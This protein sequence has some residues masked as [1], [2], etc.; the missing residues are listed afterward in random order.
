MYH[1]Y[2][3]TYY[4]LA[5]GMDG[6]PDERDFGIVEAQNE[7]A[8]KLIVAYRESTTTEERTWMLGCLTATKL[9]SEV[10]ASNKSTL[11]YVPKA[12]PK[13]RTDDERML[14]FIEGWNACREAVLAGNAQPPAPKVTDAMC[15]GL[16]NAYED[17]TGDRLPDGD[18]EDYKIARR[19][20]EAALKEPQT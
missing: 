11:A 17:C 7:D 9:P 8:A 3:V 12:K 18:G 1:R 5:T 14:G 4:Y 10:A 13:R 16:I 15:R 6:V 19:L 20:L 2:H